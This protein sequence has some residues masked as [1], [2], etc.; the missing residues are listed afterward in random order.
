MRPLGAVWARARADKA[1]DRHDRKC[2]EGSLNMTRGHTD[3]RSNTGT[4]RHNQSRE[5]GGGPGDG[6]VGH[7]LAG[8]YSGELWGTPTH[9]SIDRSTGRT[10]SH[11]RFVIRALKKK[12]DSTGL[13]AGRMQDLADLQHSCMMHEN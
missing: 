6:G 11:P 7:L 12:S 1:R 2:L 3:T 13:R 8:P 10:M 5:S 4:P 9:S